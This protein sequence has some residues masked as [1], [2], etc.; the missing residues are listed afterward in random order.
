MKRILIALAVVF[1][2][3]ASAHAQQAIFADSM[4]AKATQPDTVESSFPGGVPAWNKFLAHNLVYPDK[5]VRKRVDGTVVVQFI[6]DKDGSIY[7]I[8]AISGPKLLQDAAMDVIRNS[9]KWKPAIVKSVKLK[10][11][12]KQPITFKIVEDK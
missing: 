12:K 2:A 10:S 7:D 11:Y 8:Q 5:A 1:F 4:D 3:S 6:V 9:P